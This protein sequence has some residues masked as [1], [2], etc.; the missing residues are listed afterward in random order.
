MQWKT[1]HMQAPGW[2]G[3]SPKSLKDGVEVL[4]LTL[5]NLVNLLI[6]Q[7]LLSDKC[8]IAELLSSSFQ[9]TLRITLKNYFFQQKKLLFEYVPLFK[10]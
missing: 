8:K 9:N 6:K 10:N 2:D 1:G 4:V 3:I 5:R 7:S